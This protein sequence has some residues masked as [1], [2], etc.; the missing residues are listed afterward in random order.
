MVQSFFSLFPVLNVTKNSEHYTQT[1]EVSFCW[2]EEDS[3]GTS[4]PWNQN[5]G[6][7]PGFLVL[8]WPSLSH[9]GAEKAIKPEMSTSTN[10][11]LPSL[12]K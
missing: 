8:F 9:F 11:S 1:E 2:S 7:F 4:G 5:S 3:L 12:V 6:E 10:K